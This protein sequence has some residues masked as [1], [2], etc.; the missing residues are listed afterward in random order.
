MRRI[1]KPQILLIDHLRRC[2]SGVSGADLQLRL[3]H[4]ETE[5]S[6]ASASFDL[7]AQ[8]S[9]LHMVE[10]NVSVLDVTDQEMSDLYVFQMSSKSGAAKS[11]YNQLLNAAPS[12]KCPH[13]GINV[14]NTLDHHLPKSQY[15]RLSVA[16]LNL[17][18]CCNDC[19]KAKGTRYPRGRDDQL[20]HP[21]YDDF[22]KVKWVNATV[23]RSDPLVIRYGV[24]PHAAWSTETAKRAEMHFKVFKLAILFGLNAADDLV[25]LRSSLLDVWRTDGSKGLARFLAERASNYE[26]RLNSWQ[27]SLYKA[28]EN[29]QWFLSGGFQQIA[30]QS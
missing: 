20:V 3:S 11:T 29:D 19:N 17:V 30:M 13:C 26:T 27:H 12:K 10:R 5:L 16:P 7:R 28:L 24:I 2:T 22:T 15:P 21:Y 18:P 6:Q 14:A 4:A 9:D 8:N 23:E 1:P 25:T